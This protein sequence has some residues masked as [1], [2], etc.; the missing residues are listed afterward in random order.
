MRIGG[1]PKPSA[2][3]FAQYWRLPLLEKVGSPVLQ[4]NLIFMPN[5]A[6]PVLR[7]SVYVGRICPELTTSSHFFTRIGCGE[8]ATRSK[9]IILRAL[10]SCSPV[11]AE[12]NERLT[13]LAT[14]LMQDW[15]ERTVS[16]VVQGKLETSRLSDSRSPS[17][18][19]NTAGCAST[20]KF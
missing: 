5:C 13:V 1:M 9:A 11:L 3:P 12:F 19:A 18:G 17:K 7:I 16:K 4:S 6:E 20:V 8:A 14:K 2:E 10:F 15:R